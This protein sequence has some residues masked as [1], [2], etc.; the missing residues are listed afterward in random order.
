MSEMSREDLLG[1]VRRVWE[2]RDPVPEGLVTRMQ[3]A[4]AVVASELT[5]DL[6]APLRDP[7]DAEL[8]ELVERSTELAGARGSTAYTL[9]F[10]YG[11]VDLL[12]RIAVEGEVSRV[13]GWV[14]PPRPMTVQAIPRTGGGAVVSHVG[15][16]GR[17][18]LTDLPVGQVQ[19][20]LEPRDEDRP[21]IATPTFE[22]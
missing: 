6:E 12:L 20:R 17:F 8:M 1:V 3:E 19:L 16:T 11:D 21:A 5:G 7:L 13:D 4:A 15:D 14:V 2:E 22:I 9:R 18:V 10:V